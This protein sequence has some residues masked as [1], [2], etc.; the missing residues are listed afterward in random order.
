MGEKWPRNFAVSD[1][2]HVTFGVFYMP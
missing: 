2:F 1:D